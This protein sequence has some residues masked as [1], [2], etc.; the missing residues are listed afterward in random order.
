MISKLCF[1]VY[2]KFVLIEN[3]VKVFI[4]EIKI[5]YKDVIYNCLVYIVGLE[6]NI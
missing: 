3:E 4:D 1:I 5:K 2:I 6:M